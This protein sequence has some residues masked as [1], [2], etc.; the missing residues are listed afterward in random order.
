[1]IYD[2]YSDGVGNS[3]DRFDIEMHEDRNKTILACLIYHDRSNENF[4]SLSVSMNRIELSDHGCVR[5]R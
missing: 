5:M 1:V 4:K 3:I 2:G